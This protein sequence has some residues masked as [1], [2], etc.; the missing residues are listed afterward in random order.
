MITNVTYKRGT[1]I[2]FIRA[3]GST[4]CRKRF[5]PMGD[6]PDPVANFSLEL[7]VYDAECCAY[8]LYKLLEFW[9]NFANLSPTDTIRI[10]NFTENGAKLDRTVDLPNN[11]LFPNFVAASILDCLLLNRSVPQNFSRFSPQ[12]SSTHCLSVNPLLFRI[13]RDETPK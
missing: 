6:M 10:T 11:E 1:W 3:F 9:M 2:K 5:A 12:T 4:E 7:D 8:T 13:R